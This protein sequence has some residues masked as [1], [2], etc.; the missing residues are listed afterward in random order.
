MSV[1]A[2]TPSRRPLSSGRTAAPA[3]PLVR[4]RLRRPC[5]PRR[6]LL[7][8]CPIEFS[9]ATVFLF[10]GPHNWFEVRYALGRLPARAGK[11]WGFFAISA[12]GIVGSHAAFAA[13]PWLTATSDSPTFIGGAYAVWNTTFLFWVAT[14]VWMRSRTNPHFDGG[15]VWPLACLLAAGVWLSPLALQRGADLPAPAAG[16]LAARSRTGPVAARVAARPTGARS[17]AIPLLM[18]ALWWR[19]ADAPNLTG[20]PIVVDHRPIAATTPRRGS[21]TASRRTSWSRRTRSWR[22]SITACGSCSFR[23]W[24]CARDPG[25]CGR[26]PRRGGTVRGRAACRICCSS[27]C[28]L[29]VVLW[30]CFLLDYGTTR[31]IYFTVAMLHV[32]AEIPFLLRMV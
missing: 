6:R 3:R 14:L 25:N 31:S 32:L 11:L 5:S 23:W 2:P 19:L 20:R 18:A 9:I 16:T 1:A 28:W 29:C 26:S 15:W 22:W 21:S 4:E 27:G 8:P 13:I 17:P 30:V 7:R 12:V 10:A 24:G